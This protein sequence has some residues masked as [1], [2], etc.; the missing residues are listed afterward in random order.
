MQIDVTI[1]KKPGS[2]V[3][4]TGELPFEALERHRASAVS[5]LSKDIQ[6]DGFRK[7]HVPHDVLVSKIGEMPIITEMAE[8]A[9]S[10]AY[11][12]IVT[13]NSLDVIGY[14]Q[15]SITKIAKG[16]PLGFTITVAVVPSVTL[17]DYF[18]LAQK[19]NADKESKEVTDEEVEG[20]IKDILRQKVAY[21]RLQ[22]KAQTKEHVHDENCDHDHDPAP[23]EDAKDLPLPELTD[24][25]VQALGKPGQFTGVEDFK[26]KI[27]EHLTIQKAQ[28]VDSRHRAKITDAIIAEATVEM[29]QVL[30]DAELNQMFAQMETD[31]ERAQLKVEDYLNH[32]KKTKEDLKKDWAPSAEKRAKLQ[33]VLNEIAKRENIT[34]DQSLVDTQVDALLAQYKDADE[35]RVRVYVSSVLTNEAVL[36]KLEET[37]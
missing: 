21:E 15:I 29:P 2:L 5:T 34:P 22:Q 12:H 3:T 17:P 28:D 37:K 33:L 4:I 26:T 19:I 32:I 16:N 30:V 23:I 7:G 1:E 27:R 24:E 25:Y 35:K 31:L 9:L 6:I 11:P 8:R 20:Q 10:E 36:K 13:N 18:G 14:P